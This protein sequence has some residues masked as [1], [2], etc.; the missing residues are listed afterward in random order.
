ML[1]LKSY[2]IFIYQK[3]KDVLFHFCLAA[4]ITALLVN[5]STGNDLEP[6]NLFKDCT[7]CPEIIVIPSGSFNMGSSQGKRN[8]LPIQ[9]ITIAKPYAISR[10]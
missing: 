5:K 8:E 1:D 2:V 9:E 4:F 10:F 7:V 3:S 6:G